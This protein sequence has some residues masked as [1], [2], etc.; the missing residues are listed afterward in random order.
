MLCFFILYLC[1]FVVFFCV[2]FYSVIVIFFF[3]FFSS[4]RRHTR[5]LNDWSSDVC[6]SDLG[7]ARTPGSFESVS[8]RV[9]GLRATGQGAGGRRSRGWAPASGDVIHPM[10]RARVPVGADG[11]AAPAPQ[12]GRAHV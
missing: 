5:C 1:S 8:L 10:R 6:S 12:I 7:P 11:S 9:C 2:V 4:R 3:F